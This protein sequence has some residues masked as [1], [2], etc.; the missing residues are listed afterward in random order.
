MKNTNKSWTDYRFF[1][2]LFGLDSELMS[3][4]YTQGVSLCTFYCRIV[5]NSN[6]YTKQ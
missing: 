4:T 5:R 1:P 2:N 6:M 3:Q